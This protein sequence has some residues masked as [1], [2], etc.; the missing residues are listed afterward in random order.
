MGKITTS[1]AIFE[2]TGP[3]V[4]RCNICGDHGD[5]TEDH[6]PPKGSVTITSVEMHHILNALHIKKPQIK[7]KISQNGIKFRTL[8][9]RCNN[10][11]LGSIYDKEFNAFSGNIGKILKSPLLL[12]RRM[13]ITVKPQKLMRAVIGHTLAFGIQRYAM[14]PC[15]EAC[16]EY[17]LDASK[18]LP[19]QVNIYYWVYPYTRQVLIRDAVLSDIRIHGQVLFKLLK[20][21][22]VSYMLTYEQPYGYDFPLESLGKYRELDADAEAEIIIDLRAVPPMNWPEAPTSSS[23]VLYGEGAMEAIPYNQPTRTTA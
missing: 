14:G 10:Q 11:L 7:G 20:T 9:N 21:Y 19:P 4:G 5:L 15:E 8:C 22:P 16:A 12:P 23:M 1:K 18:A 6:V 17:F 2:L 3:K 13:P